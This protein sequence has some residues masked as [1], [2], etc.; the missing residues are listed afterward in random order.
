V[1]SSCPLAA[2]ED[3]LAGYEFVG[4]LPRGERGELAEDES[5]G[6]AGVGD[7]AYLLIVAAFFALSFG[8]ARISPR[9]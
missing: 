4:R 2:G 3:R 9:L 8:Y 1:P 5:W 7:L 6:V